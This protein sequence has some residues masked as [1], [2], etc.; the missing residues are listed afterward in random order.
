MEHQ[1]RIHVT[2]QENNFT[3]R[4]I[5]WE[6]FLSFYFAT[7][8][9]NHA[10]YGSYYVQSIKCIN[11]L[12]PGLKEILENNCIP[13]QAQD[14]YPIRTAMDQRGKQTLS[15]DAKT[16]GGV[17]GFAVNQA[18]ILRWTFN[19][20]KHSCHHKFSIRGFGFLNSK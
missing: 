3:E 13:V 5:V 2:V 1:L 11:H 12:Y 17:K 19:T 16:T 6:Y 18:T 15:K 14:R 10:R 9:I 7:N 20:T 4:I 8:N